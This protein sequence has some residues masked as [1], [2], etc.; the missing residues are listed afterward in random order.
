MLPGRNLPV[1]NPS[2]CGKQVSR[3]ANAGIKYKGMWTTR[4]ERALIHTVAGKQ[5]IGWAALQQFSDDSAGGPQE[6]PDRA[7]AR[8]GISKAT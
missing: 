8:E 3:L 1:R 7:D 5:M 4:P 2:R 6:I